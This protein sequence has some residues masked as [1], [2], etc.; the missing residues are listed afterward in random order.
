M[1][2]Q[3]I[4]EILL[5][6]LDRRQGFDPTFVVVVAQFILPNVRT[7]VPAILMECL[8]KVT[9]RCN[10]SLMLLILNGLEKMKGPWSRSL[11]NQV[12]W[13]FPHPCKIMV[14]FINF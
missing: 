13:E 5:K 6:L 12:R 10:L 7:I 3:Q 8:L 2:N 4:C 9:P 1:F 14:F 11:H